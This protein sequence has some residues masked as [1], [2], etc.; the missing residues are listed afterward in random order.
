LSDETRFSRQGTLNFIDN[1]L[2]RSS[3]TIH[4]RAI[5][6]NDDL[7]L[8]PGGFARVRLAL[9]TPAPTLL[10]PDSAVLVDQSDHTV[11]TIGPDNVVTAKKVQL[12]DIRYGLRVIRSGLQPSDR[13]IIDGIPT[14]TP[15]AKAT[16]KNESIRLVSD[17]EQK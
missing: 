11:L 8:T 17:E 4:A 12:G 10:V 1:T 16:P 15:G 5:F 3:G 7:L 2:D 6:P 13:V 14:V 9:S